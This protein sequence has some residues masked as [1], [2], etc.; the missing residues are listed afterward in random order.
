MY[1]M[2]N[3]LQKKL[4]DFPPE[5]YLISPESLENAASNYEQQYTTEFEKKTYKEQTLSY[6]VLL[7]SNIV[8]LVQSCVSRQIVWIIISGII[9]LILFVLVLF[10]GI[11]CYT[12]YKDSKALG[13]KYKLQQLIAQKTNIIYTGI[14]RVVF[15]QKGKP[16]YLVDPTS[17]Y[18]P[19]IRDLSPTSIISGL[20]DKIRDSLSKVGIEKKDIISV[21][22][23][24]AIPH[25]SIKPIHGKTELNA[26]IFFDVELYVQS[27]QKLTKQNDDRKWMTIEDMEKNPVACAANKDVIDLLSTFSNP[28]ESFVN[29][30]GDINI[31]WN[32]TNHCD[33]NCEICATF[34]DNREEIDAA[35]KLKVLNSICT[36]KSM[37]KSLDFAGGDPFT[38]ENT[39]ELIQ[40]A[41]NQL[42]SNRV[43]VTTTGAG[44]QK[45]SQE[46]LNDC[47]KHCEIT[48][49]AAHSNLGAE[50]INSKQW[51]R[52]DAE[53][54]SDN[55]NQMN[56]LLDY[57][58]SV[59]INIP[60][61]NDDLSD[62]EIDTLVLKIKQVRELY[63]NT[64]ID[65]LLIRL[66]PVGKFGRNVHKDS[67]KQ[68]NPIRVAKKIK[69]LLE[70]NNISCR[71][72]C[73]LRA[74][75]AFQDEFPD[76]PC[77]M[78]ESKIGI[79]CEGNVFACAWGGYLLSGGQKTKNPFY[80]GNLR[81]TNLISLLKGE[82][83]N[84]YYRDLFAQIASKKKR[85][86][87]SVVSY[88]ASNQLFENSDYLAQKTT[89]SKTSEL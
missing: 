55:I 61:I 28:Q 15:K 58:E 27:K 12:R 52:G 77:S 44:I 40:A 68:Y 53:Y 33:Y 32:V 7:I 42:G 80:L 65:T 83:K 46:K 16:H 89:N 10:Y 26:Y 64:P 20:D 38:S 62:D 9:E 22:P 71:L 88:Y 70:D 54:C 17:Y 79:D 13:E 72:H 78:L 76:K 11:Q 56:L 66:M 29:P 60:L 24:D 75:P 69:K 43:S 47:I 84:K 45:L 4:Q 86:F 21:K 34:D 37:I 81:E 57:A 85:H 39:I 5:Y 48:I 87:C 59:T 35:G 2:D 18:L 3:E 25:F 74:L 6:I 36:A 31:I 1:S 23:V 51:S 14:V 41:V 63:P 30:I 8:T 50:E 73:S 67:Y 19:Y 82:N 49:D